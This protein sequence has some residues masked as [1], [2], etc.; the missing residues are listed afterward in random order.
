MLLRMGAHY[1]GPCS[2]ATVYCGG[3]SG[4]GDKDETKLARKRAMWTCRLVSH[5]LPCGKEAGVLPR[6]RS[7][8]AA[9]A[10]TQCIGLWAP[11]DGVLLVEMAQL[12]GTILGEGSVLSIARGGTHIAVANA[13][14][15]CS[16]ARLPLRLGNLHFRLPG[17][18]DP[19]CASHFSAVGAFGSPTF[20][21]WGG[22]GLTVFFLFL[23]VRCSSRDSF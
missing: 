10:A 18:L 16:L 7:L 21:Y 5:W 12:R 2:Q 1:S 23:L 11:W 19:R 9:R 15:V 14:R 13:V 20:C 4:T 22:T 6:V 8:C 3:L 17:A